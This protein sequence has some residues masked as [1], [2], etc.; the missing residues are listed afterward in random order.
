MRSASNCQ[1]TT[2][3]KRAGSLSTFNHMLSQDQARQRARVGLPWHSLREG[4]DRSVAPLKEA[5]R[6][7][8]LGKG[9]W[10]QLLL[11]LHQHHAT[12]LRR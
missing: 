12:R 8:G 4:E 5:D 3:F 2:G 6:V 11:P 10:W 7:L 1:A 9:L